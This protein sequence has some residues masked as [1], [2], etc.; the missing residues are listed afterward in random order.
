MTDEPQGSEQPTDPQPAPAP[1]PAPAPGPAP[2]QPNWQAPPAANPDPHGLG[3]TSMG[4]AAHVAGALSY[5]FGWITGL[6]FYLME[7]QNKFVRFHAMQSLVMSGAYFILY[8]IL[9]VL[10]F[11]ALMSG[12]AGLFGVLM[13]ILNLVGLGVFILWIVCI[14]MAAQGKWFKIPVIG[15][16]ASKW[17]G[18]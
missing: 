10:L 3:P 1:A 18:V 16:M 15:D 7:K 5:V 12:S 9:G 2:N 17:A 4:M 13:L 11:P 8:I 14:V 6:I